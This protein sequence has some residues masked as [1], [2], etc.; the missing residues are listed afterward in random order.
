MRIAS[1]EIKCRVLPKTAPQFPIQTSLGDN[2]AEQSAFPQN[3]LF[4]SIT[5]SKNGKKLES[6]SD[7]SFPEINSRANGKTGHEVPSIGR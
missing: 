7:S 4:V 1:L 3:W 2:A 5:V 6:A